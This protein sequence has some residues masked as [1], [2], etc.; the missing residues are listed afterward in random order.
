MRKKEYIAL[1]GLMN[2]TY[3][4]IREQNKT[5]DTPQEI[6]EYDN[7]GVKPT[8]IH[9][10]KGEHKKQMNTM[11]QATLQLIDEEHDHGQHKEERQLTA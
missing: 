1:H 9:I 7:C 4:H 5:T 11:I 6:E 8:S 3:K 10:Q 2:V